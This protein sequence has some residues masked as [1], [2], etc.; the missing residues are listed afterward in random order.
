MKWLYF[1]LFFSCLHASAQNSRP[2]IKCKASVFVVYDV[3]D[4][5]DIT[6]TDADGDTVIL[7]SD[8]ALLGTLTTTNKKVIF[9]SGSVCFTPQRGVHAPGAHNFKIYATDGKDIV[10]TTVTFII[11]DYPYKVHPVIKRVSGLS[12]DVEVLG[13]KNEPWSNYIGFRF[14][15]RVVNDDNTVLLWTT[16][17]VFTF[18]APGKGVYRLLTSYVTNTSIYTSLDILDAAT[19]LSTTDANTGTLQVFPNPAQNMLH[20]TAPLDGIITDI[21]GKALI[22]FS[23]A[24]SLDITM[25]PV[26]TYFIKTNE[27]SVARVVKIQ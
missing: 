18:T 24:E 5:L 23:A 14:E 9:A 7:G 26:G 6:T 11:L 3:Q 25:L 10:S 27:G 20:F 17:S 19:P 12:F 22:T 8:N 15:S 16:D 1:L 4:C 2:V 13:D 21:T